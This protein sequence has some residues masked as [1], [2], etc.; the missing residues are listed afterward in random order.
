MA[1]SHKHLSMD[2]MPSSTIDGR[3]TPSK[4]DQL[5]H[6]PRVPDLDLN[7]DKLHLLCKIGRQDVQECRDSLRF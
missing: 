5:L 2:R 1:A 7:L 3:L 4:T 6:G